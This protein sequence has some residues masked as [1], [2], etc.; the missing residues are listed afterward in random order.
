VLPR[1][2]REDAA[3]R[4]RLQEGQIAWRPLWD[5]TGEDGEVI[6]RFSG[7]RQN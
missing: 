3:F 5:K 2:R 4:Q 6:D 1:T 7:L